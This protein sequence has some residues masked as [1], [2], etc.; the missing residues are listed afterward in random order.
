MY[1]PEN[2]SEYEVQI[3]LG[4]NIDNTVGMLLHQLSTHSK[5]AYIINTVVPSTENTVVACN[6]EV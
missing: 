1:P 4:P 2:V 3:F 6:N 5:V